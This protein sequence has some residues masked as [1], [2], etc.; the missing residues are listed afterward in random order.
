MS[1]C[2]ILRSLYP[3]RRQ[4]VKHTLGAVLAS[5]TAALN[6]ESNLYHLPN[7]KIIEQPDVVVRHLKQNVVVPLRV[8]LIL[9]LKHKFPYGE[10]CG[11]L[12]GGANLL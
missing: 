6:I 8:A 12:N 11:A 3:P 5:P 1:G 7:S 9:D 2:A 4:C 10:G